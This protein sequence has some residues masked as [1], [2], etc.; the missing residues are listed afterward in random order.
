MGDK[1]KA[2]KATVAPKENKSFI[3]LGRQLVF[4]DANK[5]MDYISANAGVDAL[6]EK[7][8]NTLTKT[9]LNGKAVG[10]IDSMFRDFKKYGKAVKG[11]VGEFNRL[12]SESKDPIF[13][14]YNAMIGKGILPTDEVARNGGRV[15]HAYFKA[16]ALFH[17][18][19]IFE[20]KP[21][22]AEKAKADSKSGSE[23]PGESKV[24][25]EAKPASNPIV[26]PVE[27]KGPTA[28]M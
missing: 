24:E 28:V 10:Q 26:T 8:Q 6:P 25:V 21:Q 4:D 9:F 14:G 3:I 16:W 27:P 12:V 18:V 23:K 13:S 17:L 20:A 7:Y 15:D 2:E 1:T 5:A 22:P 11:K 19:G